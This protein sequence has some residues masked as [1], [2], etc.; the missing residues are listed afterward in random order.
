VY[1]TQVYY[2]QVETDIAGLSTDSSRCYEYNEYNEYKLQL[3][4]F[5]FMIRGLH[6]RMT[7][8][9]R[10]YLPCFLLGLN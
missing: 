8:A 10:I 9:V 4:H 6:P 3:E 5:M 2:T 7:A 1:Y